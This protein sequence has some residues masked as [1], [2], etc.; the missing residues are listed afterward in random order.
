MFSIE[1][2]DK[3]Y[4]IENEYKNSGGDRPM[5]DESTVDALVSLKITLNFIGIWIQ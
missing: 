4:P 1:A 5:V 2:D 3:I